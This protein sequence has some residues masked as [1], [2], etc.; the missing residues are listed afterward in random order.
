FLA[1]AYRQKGDYQKAFEYQA[2]LMEAKDSINNQAVIESVAEMEAKYQTEQ[3]GRELAQAEL[4]LSRQR[5]A[6]NRILYGALIAILALISLALWARSR[7]R[8]RKKQAELEKA[9]AEKLRELDRI[10]SNFFANISH[11]FRTPLTLIKG[12]LQEMA[13]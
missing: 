5:S 11:E 13:E 7:A 1:D 10:K 12:P 3:Q 8:L 9:E 2:L 6:R 4:E